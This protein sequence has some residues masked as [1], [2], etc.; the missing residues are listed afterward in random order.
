MA[1]LSELAPDA[2]TGLRRDSSFYSLRKACLVCWE[3][4]RD[5][6]VPEEF[7]GPVVVFLDFYTSQL[8]LSSSYPVVDFK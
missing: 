1:L 7:R 5:R 8:L 6:H 2:W 4:C 3:P